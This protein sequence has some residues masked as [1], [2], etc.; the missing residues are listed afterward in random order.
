MKKQCKNTNDDTAGKN[1]RLVETKILFA[2]ACENSMTADV[3]LPINVGFGSH[4]S[5]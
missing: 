5:L 1:L 2:Y 3:R 4:T